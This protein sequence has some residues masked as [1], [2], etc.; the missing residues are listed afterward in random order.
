ME[1]FDEWHHQRFVMKPGITGLWQITGRQMG[2]LH[3]NDAMTTDVYYTNN[4]F[5]WMDFRILFRTIPVVIGGN[6][7]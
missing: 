2:E 7:S 6:G 3:L 4:Y 1:L 5:L